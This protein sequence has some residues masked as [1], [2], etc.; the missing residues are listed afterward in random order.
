MRLPGT[1]WR[2]GSVQ[3]RP[4]MERPGVEPVEDKPEDEPEPEK[5]KRKRFF[6]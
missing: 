6:K 5:P 1:K 2:I 4:I 3:C